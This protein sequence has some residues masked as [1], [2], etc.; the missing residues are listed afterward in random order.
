MARNETIDPASELR[1]LA[2]SAR[3]QL[4]LAASEPCP[5]PAAVVQE[6]LDRTVQ[7]LLFS[8]VVQPD[9]GRAIAFSFDL[10]RV[11]RMTAQFQEV[12]FLSP[13]QTPSSARHSGVKNG[14][15]A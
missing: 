9:D 3:G 13:P 14:F 11:V 15:G 5:I 12:V 2:G 4:T 10:V 7:P 1:S 6:R 8:T